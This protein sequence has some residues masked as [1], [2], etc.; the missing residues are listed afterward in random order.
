MDVVPDEGRVVLSIKRLQN[1]PWA[2][3]EERYEVGQMVTG[4]ITNVVDFG[5]FVCIEEGLE[6]LVHISEL[7]EGQFLHPPE[8]CARRA[9]GYSQN[10]AYRRP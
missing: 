10:F 7:A 8:C 4:K 1:D 5:A 2:G 9:Y 6:G 3:V